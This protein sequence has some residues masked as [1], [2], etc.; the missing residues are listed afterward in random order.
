VRRPAHE[1][2]ATKLAGSL[3]SRYGA[4]IILTLPF[5]RPSEPYCGMSMILTV[6]GSGTAAPEP[7]RVCSGFLLETYGVRAL[8]DCGGGVL[9]NMARMRLEWRSITHLV[10]THFHNDHIGDVPLLFFAWKHG[11]RPARSEPLTVIGPKGTKKLLQRMADIFGSHLSQPGFDVTCLELDDGDEVRLTDVVRLRSRSTP[12]TPE[13][14]AYRI[15]AN[16]RSF[17]YLGDTGMSD[18]VARFAQGVD[19]LLIECSVPDE[20]PMDTHLTPA[21][22]AAMARIALPRRLLVTHVYP[23][24]P[25]R[26]VPYLIREGGWPARV[27]VIA[28]GDRIEI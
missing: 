8:L 19:A 25:R 3:Q 4:Q 20:E 13:S 22:V 24:L 12:H 11:M 1:G 6:I 23:H 10:L 14:L 18:D 2:T 27:E 9:H 17:C 16:G 26:D 7:D 21:R 15:E 28:D 5:H